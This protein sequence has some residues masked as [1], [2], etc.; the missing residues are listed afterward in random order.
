MASPRFTNSRVYHDLLVRAAR[1]SY[2]YNVYTGYNVYDIGLDGNDGTL[3]IYYV[4]PRTGKVFIIGA[5]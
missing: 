5:Y 2:G 4:E 1:D 3:Y